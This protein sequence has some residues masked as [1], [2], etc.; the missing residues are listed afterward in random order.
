MYDSYKK[1]MMKAVEKALKDE[2]RFKIKRKQYIYNYCGNPD[3]KSSKK[4]TKVIK[5]LV[6]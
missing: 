6:S 5:G 2:K 3:G 1:D 4:V